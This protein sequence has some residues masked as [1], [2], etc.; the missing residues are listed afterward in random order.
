MYPMIR[1]AAHP[2]GKSVAFQSLDN[3]IVVYA[4]TDRFRQNRK[5]S[6]RGHNNAGQ[7]ID[8]DIS[9]DGQFVVSG[10]SGGGGAQYS[11]LDTT[12]DVCNQNIQT[13]TPLTTTS[14]KYPHLNPCNILGSSTAICI[15]TQ[16]STP[17]SSTLNQH[18][19]GKNTTLLYTSN[20]TSAKTTNAS[21][22]A[23]LVAPTL[24]KPTLFKS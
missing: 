6:F 19:V 4:S 7:A 20:I 5:K 3:Q 22:T 9:P 8:V 10:D 14:T 16:T 12:L 15:K 18:L 11:I 13:S 21:A 23:I 1:A 17:A 24:S 2:N